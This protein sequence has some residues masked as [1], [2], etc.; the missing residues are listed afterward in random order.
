[1]NLDDVFEDLET[2]FDAV[3]NASQEPAVK[4][5]ERLTATVQGNR[6]TITNLRFG[7]DFVAGLIGGKAIWRYQ[8]HRSISTAKI[9]FGEPKPFDVRQVG[10]HQLL[11]ETIVGKFVR[12][13]LIGDGQ[14]IRKGRVLEAVHG[15]VIFESNTEVF[16][17]TMDRLA[18]LE[19]HAGDN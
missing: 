5:I 3:I 7:E 1:M 13:S 12:Y 14:Q 17:V 9:F 6:V 16:A 2:H 10:S 8:P 19:V 4:A 15:L 11:S 18:W